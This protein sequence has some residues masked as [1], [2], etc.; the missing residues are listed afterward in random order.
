MPLFFFFF[1]FLYRSE[2]GHMFPIMVFDIC[3]G[4]RVFSQ[5]VHTTLFSLG[6]VEHCFGIYVCRLVFQLLC[7]YDIVALVL[8]PLSLVNM[9]PLAV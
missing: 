9:V 5:P 4:K 2:V 6:L 8:M 1:F 7:T 3:N